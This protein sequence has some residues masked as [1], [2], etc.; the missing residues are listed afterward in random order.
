M[1]VLFVIDGLGTGGA[2][3]SLSEMLPHLERRGI[4]SV[5]ACLHRRTEGVQDQ[6]L[7]SGFDVRF[8]RGHR[9]G[10]I[11]ELHGLFRS[12]HPSLVHTA[13]FEANISGRLAAVG[14]RVP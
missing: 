6:I 4:R 14:P 11:K 3:R 12:V 2:E 10:R 1:K 7:A 13:I 8:L 5:V 9:A